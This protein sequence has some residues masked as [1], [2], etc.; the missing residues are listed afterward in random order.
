MIIKLLH[1]KYL[2]NCCLILRFNGD[3]FG[4]TTSS[5][6]IHQSQ[7]HWCKVI[8]DLLEEFI[9]CSL[10]Y[11]SNGES[12]IE[13]AESISNE[14]SVKQKNDGSGDQ[15]DKKINK[16]EIVNESGSSNEDR[17]L[18]TDQNTKSLGHQQ[19]YQAISW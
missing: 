16:L 12:S 13:S 14:L 10:S 8:K 6:N 17:Q 4:S 9:Y 15:S 5:E 18:N 11:V 1:L 3:S 19:Y 2:Y 7:E